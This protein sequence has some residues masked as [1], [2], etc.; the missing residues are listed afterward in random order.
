MVREDIIKSGLVDSPDGI[1]IAYNKS[2]VCVVGEG[3]RHTTGV[4][5]KVSSALASQG[6]NIETVFQ[7]P[8]ERNIIFGLEQKDAIKAVRAIYNLYFG[9]PAM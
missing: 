5:A 3:M 2:L 9:K 7:G 4:M 1:N 6:I 8:S